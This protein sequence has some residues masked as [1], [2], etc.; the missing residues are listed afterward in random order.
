MIRRPWREASTRTRRGSGRAARRLGR[1][2]SGDLRRAVAIV[3]GGHLFAYAVAAV[4]YPILSRLYDPSEFGAF[5]AGA[6][7]LALLITITCL[8]YNNAIP[9]PER[10][11]VATDLI[12][13][14]VLATIALT[15][16]TTLALLVAGEQILGLFNAE[17]LAPYWWLLA[18]GQ[19]AGGLYL[20]LTGWAVRHRDFKGIATARI[21]Q[22]VA[23][24]LTQ[25]TTGIA[26]AS[27]A[28]LL[29]G[30]A[31]GRTTG[32]AQLS[33]RAWSRLGRALSRTTRPRVRWAARRYR[34]FPLLGSWPTLIN[35]I[36]QDAP[37]LLL[38]TFYGAT[39]GGLFAFA[40]RLIGAPVTLAV[41]SIGQVF[42]AEAAR[43]VRAGSLLQPIFRTTLRKLAVA[44]VPFLILAPLLAVL[45]VG[46]VFGPEWS[47]TG[48]YIAI[49]TPLYTT[50]VLSAPFAILEILERQDLLLVRELLRIALLVLAIVVAQVLALSAL[51]AVVLLSTAG[52]CAYI[53]HGG[54]G[55]YALT[56]HDRARDRAHT[57]APP[58][59]RRVGEA[60][61]SSVQPPSRGGQM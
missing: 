60:A 35:G 56:R 48:T 55:W 25:V 5:A 27:S 31:L 19:T 8:T 57:A 24:A 14:C 34:R 18:V 16:L 17:A 1:A 53:I 37:L 47:T 61:S 15:S 21:G 26:G 50:Q 30:D 51:W 11:E 32:G 23:T 9:L 28:G 45:L 38:I 40:Q 49:L 22:S 42:F 54:I 39:T 6:A 12:V 58:G 4:S 44:C 2:L 41:L 59:E 33:A 36:S 43:Q 7:L 46:P 13:V 29:A 10:D 20:A 52:T 3:A